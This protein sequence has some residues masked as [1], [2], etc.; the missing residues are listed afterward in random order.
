[1]CGLRVC[2]AYHKVLECLVRA[3]RG[4]ILFHGLRRWHD[5][6]SPALGTCKFG[7][8]R[9]RACEDDSFRGG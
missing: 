8:P 4:G 7:P 9:R 2:Q 1:M 3:S 5:F 6:N